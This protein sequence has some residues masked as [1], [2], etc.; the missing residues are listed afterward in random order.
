MRIKDTRTGKVMNCT[1]S[2]WEFI[3]NAGKDKVFEIVDNDTPI[4][5]IA[6]KREVVVVEV[7][8]PVMPELPEHTEIKEK[9]KKKKDE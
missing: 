9:K 2:S 5:P 4:Q 6:Q 8:E 1:K 3:V 7:P